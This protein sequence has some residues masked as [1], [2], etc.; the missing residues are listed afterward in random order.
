LDEEKNRRKAITHT[1]LIVAPKN[2]PSTNPKKMMNAIVTAQGSLL[3]YAIW[4]AISVVVMNMTVET[5]KP[6]ALVNA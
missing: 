2:R 5:A 6:Y 1:L 4:T 3:T